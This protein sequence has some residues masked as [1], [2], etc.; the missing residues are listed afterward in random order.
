MCA[1]QR[2]GSAGS[3]CEA[4]TSS[5]VDEVPAIAPK[6]VPRSRYSNI[7][8]A[9]CA[10]ESRDPSG[11]T[12]HLCAGVAG[13]LRV[14]DDDARMSLDVI[15]PDGDARSLDFQRV[16]GPGFSGLGDRVEWRFAPGRDDPLS[17]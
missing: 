8:S 12:R 9:Q 13:Y 5:A 1:G 4:P 6:P 14:H 17:R 7:E 2:T 10:L 15:E 3:P 11:G 16:A